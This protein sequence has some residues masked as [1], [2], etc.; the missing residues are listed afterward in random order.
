MLAAR[1]GGHGKIERVLVPISLRDLGLH[2]VFISRR[3]V[4]IVVAGEA[5][6]HGHQRLEREAPLPLV[7]VG[8]WFL[9]G[10]QWVDWRLWAN[11]DAAIARDAGQNRGEGLCGGPHIMRSLLIEAVKIFFQDQLAMACNQQAMN[12]DRI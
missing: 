2:A 7:P 11:L 5:A 10:K 9:L 8:K 3:S 4:V 12:V 6:S 1:L